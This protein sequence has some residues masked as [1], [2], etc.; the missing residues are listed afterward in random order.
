MATGDKLNLT[1]F[2]MTFA[3]EFNSLSL[4]NGKGGTWRPDHGSGALGTAN[5]D[6]YTRRGNNEKEIYV[7]PGFKGTSGSDL[8]LNPFAVNNGVLSIKATKVDAA[9]SSKM[10]GY[11]YASGELTTKESFSQQYGY[12][13]MRAQLPKGKGFWPAFWLLNKSGGWPPE[14][15]VMEQ[16]GHDP[17][18]I[19]TTVHTKE[20]G[21]HGSVSTNHKVA[22]VTQGFHNYGAKWDAQHVTFY[23]DGKEIAQTRTPADM[24]KPM[25][26][27]AN[28]AVGGGWPGNPDG[29]TKFPSEMKIDYIHAYALPG[30]SGGTPTSPATPTV[31]TSPSHPSTP[32][33]PPASGG[34][35]LTGTNA[36]DALV[37]K[38]GNETLK[39]LGGDDWLEGKGGAD[40]LTGGAGHDTF[41]FGVGSGKDTVTDFD[42]HGVDKLYV[43][44]H[45]AAHHIPTLAQSGA[46]TLVKFTASD[47]VTLKNVNVHDIQHTNDWFWLS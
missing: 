21:K 17:T 34:A 42:A 6:A 20:T 43:R 29:S 45:V 44:G 9:T 33:T 14:L 8:H 28:L 19:Y 32:A 36:H 3:D 24:H 25:Y 15:D 41:A 47:V 10:W 22:D 40:L 1:G 27:L 38:A 16:L 4:W 2:K 30:T 18:T 5:V 26:L 35:V 7:A 31:P 23:F 12:F 46:D 39:G 37:G 11:Q 13:E